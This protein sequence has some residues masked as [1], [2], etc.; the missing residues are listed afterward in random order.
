LVP[1]ASATGNSYVIKISQLAKEAVWG[2]GGKKKFLQH[3]LGKK[4]SILGI[5]HNFWY[6]G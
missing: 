6:L 5:W 4:V 3:T 2:R 1:R